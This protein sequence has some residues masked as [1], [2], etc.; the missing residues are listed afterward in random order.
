MFDQVVVLVQSAENLLRDV[1]LLLCGCPSEDIEADF[2]P[3]I[4]LR[5]YLIVLVT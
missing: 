3:F 4:D 1:F 5:M 2:E